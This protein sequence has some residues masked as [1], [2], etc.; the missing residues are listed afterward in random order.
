[1]LRDEINDWRGG[2]SC[3]R[4]WNTGLGSR[5]RSLSNTTSI[6]PKPVAQTVE[7]LENLE[8]RIVLSAAFYGWVGVETLPGYIADDGTPDVIQGVIENSQY[9]WSQAAADRTDPDEPYLI[10]DKSIK[11]F[12]DNPDLA[13]VQI[14][15]INSL[16]QILARDIAGDRTGELFTATVDAPG[17]R[18][19]LADMSAFDNSSF[20]PN[21]A[22]PMAIADGSG[23]VLQTTD[24]QTN[25]QSLWMVLPD[26]TLVHL[27][28]LEQ[29]GTQ[30]DIFVDTN[31]DNS[32]V[33]HQTQNEFRTFINHGQP[34]PAFYSVTGGVDDL[35][36]PESN[37]IQTFPDRV[38]SINDD[39]TIL[40]HADSEDF[41]DR[42]FPPPILYLLVKG[43]SQSQVLLTDAKLPVGN[44][45]FDTYYIRGRSTLGS[46]LLSKDLTSDGQAG[47]WQEGIFSSN[48]PGGF[49]GDDGYYADVTVVDGQPEWINEAGMVLL[50]TAGWYEP[51][52]VQAIVTGQSNDAVTLWYD[53]ET[54]FD[55]TGHINIEYR[56][57][58]GDWVRFR[59][60][61]AA[62]RETIWDIPRRQA[63]GDPANRDVFSRV[64]GLRVNDSDWVVDAASGHI[65]LYDDLESTPD[66]FAYD[67]IDSPRGVTGYYF[68]SRGDNAKAIAAMD[69]KNEL[70]LVFDLPGFTGVSS[71]SLS[72]QLAQRGLETPDFTGKL[73]SFATKWGAMNIFGLDTNGD[74]QTVWWSPGL[75]S[76]LWT[77]NNLS[78]LTGAPKL[79]G[80]IS[81]STTS[82]N[83]M[84]VMGTDEQ[85]HLIS[86]W[87]SPQSAGWHWTDLSALT[88]GQS[89][90]AGSI[91]SLVT[92]WNGISVVGRT[93]TDEL[94]TYWWTPQTKVWTFESITAEQQGDPSLHISGPTS[95]VI[96]PQS[97][98][99]HIAGMDD[100]GH[101][102]HLYWTPQN[103][104][105]HVEDL[106]NF[107]IS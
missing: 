4:V 68:R 46:L 92:P 86:M 78:E 62:D 50:H 10:V 88:D 107:A 23:I 8:P 41:G 19:Y 95:F 37:S 24:S 100:N 43:D 30:T 47:V 44:V 6:P 89:L 18:T 57:G 97:R 82:W 66:L 73:D 26:Q 7:M 34:K 14:A 80:N 27:W 3:G 65:I 1:M 48:G 5:N 39:G 31:A 91:S 33:G 84:Q 59:E 104:T 74:L 13:D 71:A 55:H 67:L 49:L 63:F 16:G 45:V 69:A 81:S 15:S 42:T 102:I 64:S 56:A 90:V 20:D 21:E 12:R 22:D 79:V 25:T 52:E 61:D 75:H 11:Y 83:G 105:W 106:T 103:D 35:M 40:T 32:V 9:I 17:T 76:P 51:L 96:N 53:K 94:V 54:G 2:C 87:W 99:Q 28:D 93:E 101:L 70:V 58:N 98:E 60:H 29:S 36:P 77:T 38:I 85:G 72:D